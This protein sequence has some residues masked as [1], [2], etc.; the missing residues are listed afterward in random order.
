MTTQQADRLTRDLTAFDN[1]C[2]FKRVMAAGYVP[3]I[4][5]RTKRHER[6][7]RLVRDSG[8][9]VFDGRKVS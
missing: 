2:E 1:F 6:L 3:T 4:H 7:V 5:P 9:Q 8:F